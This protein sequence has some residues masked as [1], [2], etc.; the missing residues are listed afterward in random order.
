MNESII[1]ENTSNNISTNSNAMEP[2]ITSPNVNSPTMATNQQQHVT[3]PQ[4]TSKSPQE[5]EINPQKTN[6][7]SSSNISDSLE[8]QADDE[9]DANPIVNYNTPSDSEII[10]ETQVIQSTPAPQQPPTRIDTTT[11][12]K[13]NTMEPQKKKRKLSKKSSTPPPSSP[14]QDVSSSTQ[15]IEEE[16]D[17]TSPRRTKRSIKKTPKALASTSTSPVKNSS[18]SSS[19]SSGGSSVVGG[20]RR[21]SSQKI[22]DEE[23]ESDED[24]EHVSN[25]HPYV[26][27]TGTAVTSAQKS[28]INKLGGRLV[29]TDA[30]H[31]HIVE[32]FRKN[33]ITHLVVDKIRRTFKFLCAVSTCPHIVNENWIKDSGKLKKWADESKYVLHDPEAEKKFVMSLPVTMKRRREMKMKNQHLFDDFSF[34]MTPNV[35]PPLEEMKAIIE[36]SGGKILK[37]LSSINPKV[38]IVTCEKDKKYCV[39]KILPKSSLEC[40]YS[41]EIVLSSVMHYQVDVSKNKMKIK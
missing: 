16:R 5:E 22:K 28:I 8:I 30:T 3:S 39:D 32:L 21:R 1:H 9:I 27:F 35:M 11:S 40:F 25:G 15:P 34:F 12:S 19:S 6:T 7:S 2:P 4:I 33:V 26:L 10:E 31:D 13:Q 20:K 37:T 18:K 17:D 24:Q 41:N 23:T 14:I 38:I 36:C 29:S